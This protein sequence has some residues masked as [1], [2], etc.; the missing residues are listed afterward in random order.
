MNKYLLKEANSLRKERGM[1]EVELNML[2]VEID[3]LRDTDEDRMAREQLMQVI[4]RGVKEGVLKVGVVRGVVRVWS[5]K[6][7]PVFFFFLLFPQLSELDLGK[8]KVPFPLEDVSLGSCNCGPL[9]ERYKEELEH[10]REEVQ[11]RMQ[12]LEAVRKELTPLQREHQAMVEELA[13]HSSKLQDVSEDKAALQEEVCIE[14]GAGEGERKGGRG[15]REGR[16]REGEERGWREGMDG[17]M[18]RGKDGG[19]ASKGGGM[20]EGSTGGGGREKLGGIWRREGTTEG[21]GEGGRG[22]GRGI[23]TEE[24]FLWCVHGAVE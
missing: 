8:L 7:S 4:D 18:E 15:Q 10:V 6:Y 9:L 17:S 23:G 5:S 19:M 22:I 21:E 12:E 24:L 13:Q 20:S 16:G 3:T 1:K 11:R 14:R 2:S